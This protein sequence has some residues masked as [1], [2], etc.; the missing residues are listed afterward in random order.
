MF[1]H[2]HPVIQCCD[3][4]FQFVTDC[5]LSFNLTSYGV[6]QLF[7]LIDT[8]NHVMIVISHTHSVPMSSRVPLGV[9]GDAT[10]LSCGEC[11]LSNFKTPKVKS[12]VFLE[13]EDAV[14]MST[15]RD[16]TILPAGNMDRRISIGPEDVLRLKKPT[17]GFLCSL[18]EDEHNIEFLKFTISDDESKRVLFEVGQNVEMVGSME[19]DYDTV[20]EDD[21]V[22]AIKYTFCED[23]LRLPLVS[24]SLTF[25]VGDMPIDNFR[26]IER[27]Y[28]RDKLIKSYD[29]SFGF[30]IP[31]SV[32][33]W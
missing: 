6:S 3:F 15:R 28:F 30:C 29:F 16:T 27:H 8:R 13:I 26:M 9:S 18:S 14:I 25:K 2:L 24:T 23:V 19:V 22:R 4:V 12:P 11:K 5:L 10:K 31:G 17:N 1:A 32:N 20:D 33:C 21:Y 7:Q